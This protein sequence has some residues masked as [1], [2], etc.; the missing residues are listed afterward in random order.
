MKKLIIM[1]VLVAFVQTGAYARGEGVKQERVEELVSVMGMM[2]SSNLYLSYMNISLIND[3]LDKRNRWEE[4][5]E[6]LRTMAKMLEGNK[7]KLLIVQK[8]RNL[9]KRDRDLI[10]EVNEILDLLIVDCNLLEKYLESE[11]S[12]DYDK[13][14]EMHKYVYD[15]INYLMEEE[16]NNER[17]EYIAE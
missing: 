16:D 9:A 5:E 13:F 8:D 3:N 6:I 11:K 15:R 10:R 1:L 2:T 12:G 7:K 4:Y 17:E 14:T